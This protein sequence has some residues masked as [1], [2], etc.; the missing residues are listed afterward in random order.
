M[1]SWY[2]CL[3]T[4]RYLQTSEVY[5]WWNLAKPHGHEVT[6]EWI[7]NDLSW[8]ILKTR[9][10]KKLDAAIRRTQFG[11]SDT[12][13]NRLK[14]KL[15]REGL[16]SWLDVRWSYDLLVVNVHPVYGEPDLAPRVRRHQLH[17]SVIFRNE[18][19]N[20]MREV[21][22]LINFWDG[23][24]HRIRYDDVHGRG[25][26]QLSARDPVTRAVRFLHDNSRRYANRPIHTSFFS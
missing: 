26:G 7:N 5:Q 11:C 12:E 19:K 15:C 3:T 16:L 4:G 23:R 17:I 1:E 10:T 21:Q 25:F 13:H 18:A 8:I 22:Q 24:L 6:E 20:Y 14:T 9:H 2:L